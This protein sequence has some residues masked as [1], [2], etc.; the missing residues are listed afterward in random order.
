MS[1]SWDRGSENPCGKDITLKITTLLSLDFPNSFPACQVIVKPLAMNSRP[2]QDKGMGHLRRRKAW[3]SLPCGLSRGG[4][5]DFPSAMIY[6]LAGMGQA[7]ADILFQLCFIFPPYFPPVLKS[8]TNGAF[9]L[10]CLWAHHF[11]ILYP[12]WFPNSSIKSLLN[13]L[14]L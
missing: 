2:Q 7:V 4:L 5:A 14:S 3:F 10:P 13:I 12:L 6:F 11:H 8:W 9:T 1:G